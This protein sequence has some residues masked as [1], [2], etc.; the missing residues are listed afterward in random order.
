MKLGKCIYFEKNLKTIKFADNWIS[1]DSIK[2]GKVINTKI[3][4]NKL[5]TTIQINDKKLFN[6]L[7]KENKL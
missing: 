4:K 3:I 2:I 7:K 5:V 6:T 1:K